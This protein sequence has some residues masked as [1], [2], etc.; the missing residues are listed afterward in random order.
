MQA[1][2]SHDHLDL[3]KTVLIYLPKKKLRL[4]VL[5]FPSLEWVISVSQLV[6]SIC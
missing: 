5:T 2:W 1:G 3:Q 4:S 6:I